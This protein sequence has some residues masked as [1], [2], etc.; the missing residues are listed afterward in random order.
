MDAEKPSHSVVKSARR[1]LEIF[2]FFAGRQ[3]PATVMEVSRELG[4]PQSSTSA[5]MESLRSLGYLSYD[6]Y[7]RQFNPT[8]RVAFMGNWVQESMYSDGNLF[9]LMVDLQ[10]RS[11]LTV[12]LGLQ[13]DI[14]VQYIHSIQSASPLRLF[15]RPGTLRPLAR[16][17]IGKMLLSTKSDKEIRALLTR[18]NATEE[19]P[20]NRIKFADLMKDIEGCRRDGYYISQGTVTH[21]AGV[22]AMLL[23]ESPGQPPMGLGIGAPMSRLLKKKQ[24]VID[25][26]QEAL[27][28]QFGIRRSA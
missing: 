7:S 20:E 3:A 1:V 13:N 25:M 27:Q 19:V 28:P 11:E 23:P 12:I 9:R 26:L 15:V 21:G 16:A 4:Y 6:R 18:I 5:L 22:I 10:Q 14:Y 2:E 24:E 8:L 17:A